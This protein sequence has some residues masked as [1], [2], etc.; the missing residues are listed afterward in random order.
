MAQTVSRTPEQKQAALTTA[1]ILLEIKAVNFRPEEPYILTSGWASPVYVDCRKVISFPRARAKISELMSA[2][3]LREVGYESSD[4]IAGGE[5]AGIPYAAWVSDRLA[6]P[7]LY[8]RKKPKGFGRNAQIEGDFKD[9]DR[10]V[11]VED[12]ASDGASKVNF[13]NALRQAGAK[14]DHSFVVFFYGVFPGALKSLEEIGV[15]M[16]Y[17]CNWWDVLEVVEEEGQF[18]RRAVEEVRSFLHDPVQWSG[19]H[20]G[21]KE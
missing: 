15:S 11:L 18:D 4:A 21:R 16:G 9:G 8:I 19:L 12:L 14:V 3:I 2:A 5:T 10:V 1:R 7:M 20:G 17:L 6:L 13:V